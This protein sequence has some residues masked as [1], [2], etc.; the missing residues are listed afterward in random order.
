VNVLIGRVYGAREEWSSF[1]QEDLYQD[2]AERIKVIVIG[3]VRCGR[4]E[5]DTSARFDANLSNQ[6]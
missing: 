5:A 1:A 4:E 3:D 2:L 6:R